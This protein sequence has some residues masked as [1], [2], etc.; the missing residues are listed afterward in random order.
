MSTFLSNIEKVVVEHNKT[1]TFEDQVKFLKPLVGI[2]TALHEV[3][4]Y[5]AKSLV[6]V[7]Y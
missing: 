5:F 3:L 6:E 7:V 2:D 4:D 1:C